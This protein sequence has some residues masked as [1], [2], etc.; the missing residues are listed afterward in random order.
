MGST[1]PR[2]TKKAIPKNSDPITLDEILNPTKPLESFVPQPRLDKDIPDRERE[3]ELVDSLTDELE[4]M[5]EANVALKGELD[6][7]KRERD[8][9]KQKEEQMKITFEDLKKVSAE[10]RALRKGYEQALANS[11]TLAKLF[12][13]SEQKR[14]AIRVALANI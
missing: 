12:E 7:V 10:L 8:E 14:K 13:E 11:E 6:D 4:R 5:T 9:L 3:A 1:D 2:S